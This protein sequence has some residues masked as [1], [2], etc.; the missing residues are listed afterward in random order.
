MGGNRSLHPDLIRER[1]L[2][3]SSTRIALCL[4]AFFFAS[5]A[6]A[7]KKPTTDTTDAAPKDGGDQFTLRYKFRPDET[8]RTKVTH[9][10][11]VRTTIEGTTQTAESVS[12]SVKLWRITDVDEEGNV[13][14]EHSVEYVDMKNDLTGRETVRYDSRTDQEPPSGFEDVAKRVGVPLTR[15]V[16]DPT[17]KILQREELAPGMAN[18]TQLA[19]PLPTEPVKVGD[20]WNFPDD[21]RIALR[22]G[23]TKTIKTRQRF[24]LKS[25]EDGVAEIE[26][27]TQILTPINSKEVEAQLVQRYTEGTV[28]FDIAAGRML[29]QQIDLDRRVVGY[30]ND[31]S[32]MHYRTRFTEKLLTPADLTASKP[33][34]TK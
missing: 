31:K 12:I 4:V 26:V 14:F 21:L 18:P 2:A 22:S 27:A 3:M 20:S 7:D 9:Q 15:I 24:E 13:S 19:L 29:G 11:A 6:F 8:V 32:S 23:T 33:K 5:F 28:R 16:M 1:I 34:S 30:P 10:A 17:G 25:V